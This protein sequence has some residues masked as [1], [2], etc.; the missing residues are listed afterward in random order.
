IQAYGVGLLDLDNALTPATGDPQD[1]LAD[2]G[3]ALPC[4]R[5]FRRSDFD[6]GVVQDGMP[7]FV[8]HLVLRT[9]RA[10]HYLLFADRSGQPFHLFLGR[11]PPTRGSLAHGM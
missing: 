5:S 3:E 6:L 10:C 1:M 11:H 7:I 2:F 4:A 9:E 8:R